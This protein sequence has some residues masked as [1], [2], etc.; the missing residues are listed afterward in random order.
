M[1][2]LRLLDTW[3]QAAFIVHETPYKGASFLV[4]EQR[5][6]RFVTYAI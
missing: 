2:C 1:S 3:A 6:T 5:V 4:G